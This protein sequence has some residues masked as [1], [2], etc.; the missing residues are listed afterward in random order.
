[1]S[2]KPPFDGLSFGATV[3]RVLQGKPPIPKDHPNLPDYDSL[4]KPMRRCWDKDPTARPTIR[5]VMEVGFYSSGLR[6]K[7]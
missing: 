3:G 7:Y 5:E 6:P 2:G 4:W 1:M